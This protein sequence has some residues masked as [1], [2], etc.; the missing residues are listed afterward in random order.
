[1]T[2]TQLLENIAPVITKSF[3]YVKEVAD[4]IVSHPIFYF[5]LGFLVVGVVIKFFRAMLSR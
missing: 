3:E 2:M 5:T 1:M 4:V